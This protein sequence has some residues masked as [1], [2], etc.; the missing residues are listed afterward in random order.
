MD[1]GDGYLIS[2]PGTVAKGV[3]FEDGRITSITM[4][5]GKTFTGKFF[6]DATYEGDLFASAGM[7]FTVGREGKDIHGESLN[8][9]QVVQSTNHD[10]VDGIDP[11]VKPGDPSSGLLKWIDPKGPGKEH[12]S[13]HRMQAYC[14]RMCLTNHD[15]NRIPFHKPEG[16]DESWF[17]MLFRNYEAGA[18]GI[19]WINSSMPDR[20]TDTNNRGTDSPRISSVKTTTGRKAHTPSGRRSARNIYST[21]KASCGAWR[22]I[23]EFLKAC[24]KEVS[25]WGMTKDE[26]TEGG[27]WQQQIY[28]REA[29]RL[30]SDYVMTQDH[31]R[32]SRWRNFPSG[33]VPTRW[34]LT[35]PSATSRRMF[36]KKRGRHRGRR[37]SS[38]RD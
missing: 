32:A 22:I 2:K 19:P 7:T 29:R 24:R 13:D 30:V 26:F 27:G 33:W 38:L 11:Y 5:S 6:M 31:C 17:E 18:K 4:E 3:A 9:V 25:K 34:I 1:R 12:A 15:P 20:K 37:I 28:V 21:S 35:T 14:F 10:L 36:R 16:Y 8:G 23:R